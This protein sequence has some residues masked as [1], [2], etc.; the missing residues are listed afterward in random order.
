M[1]AQISKQTGVPKGTITQW[2]KRYHWTET[3]DKIAL[4]TGKSVA[5]TVAQ[6][7][8]RQSEEVRAL[9]AA[10][11]EKQAEDLVANPKSNPNALKTLIDASDKLF[12]W[13]RKEQAGCLVQVGIVGTMIPQDE[14]ATPQEPPARPATEP[15]GNV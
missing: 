9:L 7:I 5:T 15:A 12:G 8:E 13:S 6:E 14:L 2:A 1:P 11:A 3:R 4:G 10:E